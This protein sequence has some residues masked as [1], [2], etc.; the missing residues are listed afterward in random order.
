METVR[1]RV[2]NG[3]EM[4]YD[5]MAGKFGIFYVNFKQYKD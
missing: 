2:W 1:F 3:R 4:V 5:I